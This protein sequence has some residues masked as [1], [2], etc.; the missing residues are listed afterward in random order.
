MPTQ[1][2]RPEPMWRR[3]IT[4]LIHGLSSGAIRWFL[5]HTLN[6]LA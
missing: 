2:A 5:G 4:A 6:D 1:D 3:C